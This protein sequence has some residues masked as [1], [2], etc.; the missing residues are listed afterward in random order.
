MKDRK[1]KIAKIV[2]TIIVIL[3]IIISFICFGINIISKKQADIVALS[4]SIIEKYGLQFKDLNSNG[5]LDKYEDWR[6]SNEERAEDLISKM[7]LE[8]KA[9]M[10]VINTQYSGYSQKDKLLTSH[11]GIINEGEASNEVKIYLNYTGSTKTIEELN[12]RHFIIRENLTAEEN[13]TWI[14][15]MNEIAEGTRLG[16]PMVAT[17]NPI[18]NASTIKSSGKNLN[19]TIYPS[20]LGIAAASMGEEKNNGSSK[21]IEEFAEVSRDELTSMGIRKGYLYDID[22]MTD[23][24]WIRNSETFGENADFV[25]K[26]AETLV[27]VMQGK[28]LLQDNGIALTMK[29]FPGSGARKNGYDAHFETGRYSPYMTDNS[30]E[31][32]HLKPF[33]TAIN[34]GV[35]SIM[36][37]YSQPDPKSSKQIYNGQEIDMT[38]SSYTYNSEFLT[39]LLR[40]NM[41]FKGYINTDS[42]VIDFISWGEDNK[43]NV[44]KTAKAINSGVDM[45][46]DTNCTN[47]IIEAVNQGL[48]TEER[49]NESVKRV[50][51]E[52][53]ELGLFENPYVDVEKAVQTAANEDLTNKAYKVHQK[54]VV[55]LKNNDETLPIRNDDT[56]KIYL[57]E[58]GTNGSILNAVFGTNSDEKIEIVKTPEE[59][60][61]FITYLNP[62]MTKDAIYNLD[63][64]SVIGNEYENW[65]DSTKIVKENKGKSI[66]IV[67]FLTAVSL[68][69]IEEYADSILGGFN[70][71]TNAIKDVMFGKFNPIGVLPFTIPANMEVLKVDEYGNCISPNDVPGYDK[72]K[73]MNGL[74]YEYQDENNNIYLCGF[75]ITY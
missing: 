44:E 13:A 62:T 20:T 22:V 60:D 18:N 12:I 68:D 45:I 5:E 52:M 57:K 8:E 35:S 67:N 58:Y 70:T 32:Y 43:T 29:H 38:G 2:I 33:Q 54:S 39:K 17:I 21:I 15:K 71:F 47:W 50:L 37:Y 31:K 75:G 73:Y 49:I 51:I 36:P 24:R 11:D 26:T 48:I 65:I 72:S 64:T 74:K 42:G 66:V 69:G 28:N 53:F 55:L 7:T 41:G 27:K 30:L 25:S 10:L 34:A 23:A 1:S 14:N 9:G 4:K 61:Y 16:I 3:I 19:Y 40:E 56:I 59:A 6:L 46:S 63:L